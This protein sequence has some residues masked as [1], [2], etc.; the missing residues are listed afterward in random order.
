MEFVFVGSSINGFSCNFPSLAFLVGKKYFN[1]L[2]CAFN[3]DF[4]LALRL[5]V[6][7]WRCRRNKLGSVRAMEN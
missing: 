5:W 3:E 2:E 7:R 6:F 4:G 1:E